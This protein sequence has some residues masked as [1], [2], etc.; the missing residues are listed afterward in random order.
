M[1]P[2]SRP[3]GQQGSVGDP[4]WAQVGPPLSC[5]LATSGT[6][7]A[8]SR[9]HRRRQRPLRLP[10]D[11]SSGQGRGVGAAEGVGKGRGVRSSPGGRQGPGPP[12]DGGSLRSPEAR[13]GLR[14]EGRPGP[15]GAPVLVPGFSAGGE[16]GPSPP[17]S[18]P[19]G[20]AA[21]A[22][23]VQVPQRPGRGLRRLRTSWCP[24]CSGASGRS[25]R[26]A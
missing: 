14:E 23:G 11:P 7:P 16:Q 10:P 12:K 4:C 18:W 19:R 15:S 6:K 9:Q 5:L 26:W 3:K 20:E 24:A 13:G 17:R 22:A 25:G 21:A 8:W 1:L 2:V